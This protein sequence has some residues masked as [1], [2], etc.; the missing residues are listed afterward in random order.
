MI[1]KI[2]LST[3]IF[4]LKFKKSQIFNPAFLFYSILIMRETISSVARSLSKL[5]CA[6]ELISA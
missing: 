6:D 2:L 5:F 4:T 1:S 3:V